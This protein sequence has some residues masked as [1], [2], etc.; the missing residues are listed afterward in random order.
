MPSDSPETLDLKKA[1]FVLRI[2]F[3]VILVTVCIYP[4]LLHLMKDRPEGHPAAI[5]QQAILFAG[6]L[7][8]AVV[9]YLRFFRIPNLFSSSEPVEPLQL[10]R[11]AFL[12]FLLCHIFSEATAMFGFVLAFLGGDSKY[13][14]T[15]YA[16]GVF[17]LVACYPIFPSTDS[18]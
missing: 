1:Q 6:M 16:A 11:K 9:L 7:T 17:L 3:V 13:Y 5:F 8:G 12:Y 15:L 10:A 4:A 18:R 14:V 2:V